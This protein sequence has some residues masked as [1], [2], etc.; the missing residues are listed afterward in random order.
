[1]SKTRTTIFIETD[2]YVKLLELAA[3]NK[4]SL[5][6]QV[7]TLIEV[8][9]STQANLSDLIMELLGSRLVEVQSQTS[10]DHEIPCGL[11]AEH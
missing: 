8:G 10:G 3:I 11:P 7:I 4:R 9:L 6:Q 2:L 1:M 5:N